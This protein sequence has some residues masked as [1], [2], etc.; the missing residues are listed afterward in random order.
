MAL[1]T[2][3]MRTDPH[4]GQTKA[5]ALRRFSAAIVASGLA[6]LS[7]PALAQGEPT[8]PPGCT[9][10]PTA[11]WVTV[12]AED[13]RSGD[14]LLAMTLYADD[15]RRFLVK[16]GALSVGRVKVQAGGAT[17][18]CIFLP[19]P[20]IYAIALY[21]DENG[22]TKFNR[23]MLGLPQEGWGFTNNPPTL[24]GLPSFSSV[25]LNV[26]RTGLVTRIKM[27]YP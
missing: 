17:R 5:G 13:L 24:M 19:A 14:G 2:V 12:I 26:A 8:P 7:A 16:H 20:G 15:S 6:L 4:F 10:T 9:G 11:T 1:V 25:R 3:F 27:K 23:S 22:D 21:H 18:G